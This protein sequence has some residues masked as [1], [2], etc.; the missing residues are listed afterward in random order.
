MV[1]Q[2]TQNFN[3]LMV[4]AAIAYGEK[5]GWKTFPIIDKRPS[6]KY[7]QQLASNDPIALTQLFNK[8]SHTGVGVVTGEPSGITVIDIDNRDGRTD[9]DDEWKELIDTYHDFEAPISL[10]GGGG[11]HIFVK[12]HPAFDGV[13]KLTNSIDIRSTGNLI[14]LPRSQH[15]NTKRPYEWEVS[16]RPDEI[17]IPDAPP[18]LIAYVQRK[19]AKTHNQ[20]IKMQYAKNPDEF[21]S[22]LRG[23][24]EGTRNNAAA[25]LTG[26]LLNRLDPGVALEIMKMWGATRCDPPLDEE[27]ILN[28][29]V[30]I[31]RAESRKREKGGQ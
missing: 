17:G 14:V 25:S 27:E 26:H 9:G 20:Q 2:N 16:S 1:S 12:H 19:A 21:I 5:F 13:K 23:V 28:V 8:Y 29:F 3:G 10:T 4:K 31:A 7:W 24:P 22:M 11:R 18:W 15:P 6:C 30:S